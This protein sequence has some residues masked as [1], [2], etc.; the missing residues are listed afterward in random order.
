MSRSPSGLFRREHEISAGPVPAGSQLVGYKA[1]QDVS[2]SAGPVPAGARLT[3]YLRANSIVA[4]AGTGPA[5]SR[6]C[7]GKVFPS[8]L[9]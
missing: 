3:G 5:E 2:L 4:P 6:K 9:V 8:V 7:S 1:Q